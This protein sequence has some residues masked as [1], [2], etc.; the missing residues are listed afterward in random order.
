MDTD[1]TLLLDDRTFTWRRTS[2][3][4]IV[5]VNWYWFKHTGNRVIFV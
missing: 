3:H 4:H 1:T 5:T 2:F